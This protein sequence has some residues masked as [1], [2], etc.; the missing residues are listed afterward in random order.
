MEIER[1]FLVETLPEGLE[2]YPKTHMQQAYLSTDP[3]V[4]VRR[5]DEEYVLTCKGPGLLSREE[6]EMPLT[7]EVFGRLLA[8]ADGT[9]ITKDRW[10]IPCGPYTIE[11]DVFEPP[12]APLVMAEVEFPTEEAAMAF[13]PP[14][15][16][17][18]EVT[19][20]GAYTN[21]A[22]SRR[23]G[24]DAV[25]PGRYR[26][27]KGREYRVLYTATHSETREPMVVYQALYGDH[28]IW[29]RP[30][31]MWNEEVTRDGVTY[32]RFTYVEEEE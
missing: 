3:V 13:Q 10:R 6:R 15:W 12:F 27:F 1:K 29:V 7:A 11:L 19:Q 21:A 2:Q 26:H 32:R 5:M 16:F 4:R 28:G 25:R 31:S 14:A 30:A 20:D 23:C 9:V 24:Q 8:K 18:R 17:G 22:L